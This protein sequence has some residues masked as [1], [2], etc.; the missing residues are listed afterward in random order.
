[1]TLQ[2]IFETHDRFCK[3][4]RACLKTIIRALKSLSLHDKSIYLSSTAFF[5]Y[6][7]A[8]S[9]NGIVLKLNNSK[10]FSRQLWNFLS[11]DYFFQGENEKRDKPFLQQ[12]QGI[13]IRL[14]WKKNLRC[15]VDLTFSLPLSLVPGILAGRSGRPFY[16]R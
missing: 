9:I 2:I 15:G 7:H 8:R 12:Q 6:G 13:S 1:M 10:A 11:L 5:T 3:S 4:S 14:Q 16:F